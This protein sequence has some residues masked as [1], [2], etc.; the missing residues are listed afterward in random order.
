MKS[1]LPFKVLK[2]C[3]CSGLLEDPLLLLRFKSKN[4]NILVDCGQIDHLAK[5]ILKSIS[6]VFISHAHMDHFIGFDSFT[7][8]V[9]VSN[10]TIKVFGPEGIAKKAESRLKAYDWNLTEPYFCKFILYEVCHSVIKAYTLDGSK[11]F[12]LEFNKEFSK[13]NNVIFENS[14][15]VVEAAICDHKI[16]VLIFKMTENPG[17]EVSEKKITK[18][19]FKLG[20]WINQLKE[21]YYDGGKDKEIEVLRLDCSTQ[22]VNANLLYDL[23]KRES[24]AASIGYLTD[25]GFT[26]ENVTVILKL[27]KGVDLLVSECTYLKENKQKARDSYHLCTDDVNLLL[28]T[29]HPKYFLP[30]HLSKTYLKRSEEFY[31]ELSL[32]DNCRLIRLPE[33]IGRPPQLPREIN[34]FY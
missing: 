20:P 14:Q 6:T 8:S 17:F 24:T 18:A 19:G 22:A 26:E 27:M 1:K 30:M 23:T 5:R 16:P 25:V 28:T 15:L 34:S 2:P 29:L 11:G 12:S 4:G 3:F 21:W 32:P 10:K 33:R 13:I 7:R 31:K 9:L